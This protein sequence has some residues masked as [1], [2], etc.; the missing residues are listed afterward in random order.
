MFNQQIQLEFQ[1]P[2]LQLGEKMSAPKG[3]INLIATFR[4]QDGQ[5]GNVKNLI[6]EYGE[7]VRKEPGNVFFEIYTDTEDSK[8]FVIV[9]R[10]QDQA[11][12]DAHLSAG[13]GKEF[14]QK[15]QP[16]IEGSGSEL[17]FLDRHI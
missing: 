7:I 9:E 8:D 13:V 10:Y 6:V 3:E 2:L 12:F 5:Q 15:L 14:N 4:A 11:A 17:Q 1:Q 16:L